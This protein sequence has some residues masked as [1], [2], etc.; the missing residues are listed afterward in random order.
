MQNQTVK[1]G[2]TMA[3]VAY[4]FW[5]GLFLAIFLNNKDKNTFTSFHIRQS[6][7]ILLLNLGAGFA[8]T[9]INHTFGS[10]IAVISVVLWIFGFISAL[11]GEEKLVPLFGNLFQDLFKGLS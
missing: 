5:L 10:I 9:Y 2:K 1:E 11:K 7:G 4:V 6:F 8:Y 3:I